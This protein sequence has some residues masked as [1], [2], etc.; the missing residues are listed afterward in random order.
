MDGKYDTQTMAFAYDSTTDNKEQY[1]TR[2]THT[3]V[4]LSDSTLAAIG[5]AS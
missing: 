2:L 3:A 4:Q 5:E 1:N